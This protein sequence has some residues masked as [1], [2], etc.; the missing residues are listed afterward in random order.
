MP[1]NHF[2]SVLLSV[3]K[4]K[5]VADIAQLPIQWIPGDFSPGGKATGV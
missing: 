2:E 4:G 3:W 5:K 1:Q